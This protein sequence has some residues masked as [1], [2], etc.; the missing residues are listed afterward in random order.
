[1]APYFVQPEKSLDF[2]LGVKGAFLDHSLVW[3]TNI[4]ETRLTNYQQQLSAYDAYQSQLKGTPTNTYYLSNIPGVTLRGIET[5]G[6]WKPNRNWRFS[7][8]ASLSQA[9]YADYKNSPCNPNSDGTP[10]TGVCDYT[11][12]TLPYESKFI[13]NIGVSYQRPI[14][15]NLLF[16]TFVNDTFRTHA[17]LNSSLSDFGNW[18][19]YNIAD[20]GIGVA[21][22]DGKWDLGLLAKNLFDTHYVTDISPYS[23]LQAITATPGARRYISIV[24]HSKQF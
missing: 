18:G 5:D 19:A 22:Q 2:E 6:S 15:G 1:L 11:G 17:N 3:N 4:Y 8:G 7:F 20:A 10:N 16:N 12:K 21:T 23:T 13:D 9:F 24:L 14:S